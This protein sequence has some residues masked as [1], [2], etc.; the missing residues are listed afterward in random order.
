MADYDYMEA[1]DLMVSK[2]RDAVIDGGLM[3]LDPGELIACVGMMTERLRQAEKDAARYRWLRDSALRDHLHSL[4][5]VHP[6]EWD[7]FNDEAMN[8]S[9]N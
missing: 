3:E 9:N 5:M 8:G 1:I 4:I 7:M 6:V 2:A